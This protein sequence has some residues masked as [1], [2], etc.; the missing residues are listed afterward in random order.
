MLPHL[1]AIEV[2]ISCD[3]VMRARRTVRL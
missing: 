1:T 2:S 3:V